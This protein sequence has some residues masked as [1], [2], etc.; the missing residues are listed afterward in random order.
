MLPRRCLR[1]ACPPPTN[2]RPRCPLLAVPA[3]PAPARARPA[4][5]GG[6]PRT[7]VHQGSRGGP[8]RGLSA[9][10]PFPDH[11]RFRGHTGGGRDMDAQIDALFAA[12][13]PTNASCSA[14]IPGDRSG[15]RSAGRRAAEAHA[16]L[17]REA[18]RLSGLDEASLAFDAAP[19]S[20]S[21]LA[22]PI[23][24]HALQARRARF[25]DD[26]L[27]HAA[28]VRPCRRR[29]APARRNHHQRPGPLRRRG[30]LGPEARNSV[31]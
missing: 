3:A 9:Y 27:R 30:G 22:E 14:A 25:P 23:L 1:P 31:W 28:R 7:P 24:A 16:S 12:V 8:R 19:S 2:P 17:L 15:G 18:R 26:P 4:S 13:G 20:R 11:H 10:R 29:I 21:P 6:G 5:R